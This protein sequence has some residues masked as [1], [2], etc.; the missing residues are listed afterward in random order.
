M[1]IKTLE[2]DFNEVANQTA[3]LPI[4]STAQ[5]SLQTA[6]PSYY[7]SKAFVSKIAINPLVAA[8]APLFFLVEKIQNLNL[9]PATEQLSTDLL[10]EVK[11]FETQA[12]QHGYSPKI[13]LAARYVLCAWIDEIIART[14]WGHEINW[15]LQDL[16]DTNGNDRKENR[17]FFLLLNHCS[18]DPSK[19]LE[20]LEL[21]Y[22]CMSLGYEGEYRHMDRGYILLAEI[23]DN[24]YHTISR[25]RQKQEPQLVL[26]TQPQLLQ[27]KML[28]RLLIRSFFIT[29]LVTSVISSFIYSKI[30][31]KNGLHLTTLLLQQS[32]AFLPEGNL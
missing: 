22:L 27:E 17:S 26:Q 23:R 16:V 9:Q 28:P 29:L 31:L 8:A 15:Q 21:L 24:L 4:G 11:A 13:W 30:Q 25:H 32:S 3:F 19:Y 2:M 7:R 6:N 5:A 18:Q 12:Q 14:P 10:H 20:I 1:E